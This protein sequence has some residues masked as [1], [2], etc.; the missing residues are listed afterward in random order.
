MQKQALELSLSENVSKKNL[1]S[2]KLSSKYKIVIKVEDAV[3]YF[4]QNGENESFKMCSEFICDI[5][6]IVIVDDWKCYS[7]NRCVQ[8]TS[9]YYNMD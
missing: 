5:L 6:F 1:F 8:L 7:N 9:D 3:W 2:V 4:Y